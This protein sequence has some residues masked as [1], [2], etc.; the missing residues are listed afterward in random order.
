[1]HDA[2]R[3]AANMKKAAGFAAGGFLQAAMNAAGSD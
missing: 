3:P 2:R 1:M